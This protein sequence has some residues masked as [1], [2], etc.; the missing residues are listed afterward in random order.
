MRRRVETEYAKRVKTVC[1]LR[2]RY[3]GGGG[4]GGGGGSDGDGDGNGG[5]REII[6]PYLVDGNGNGNGDRD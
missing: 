2:D 5:R 6:A 1:P 3:L 4:G